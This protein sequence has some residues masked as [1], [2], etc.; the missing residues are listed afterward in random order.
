M[1]YTRPRPKSEGKY[2]RRFSQRLKYRSSFWNIQSGIAPPTEKSYP[3][4]WWPA[5]TEELLRRYETVDGGPE[6]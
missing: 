5:L 2:N 6:T 3:G 4:S 1:P